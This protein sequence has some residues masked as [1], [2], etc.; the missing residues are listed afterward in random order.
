M[1]LKD[2]AMFANLAIFAGMVVAYFQGF[3]ILSIVSCGVSAFVLVTTAFLYRIK[4]AR[5]QRAVDSEQ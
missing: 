1:K 4:R 2:Q 5:K 3:S